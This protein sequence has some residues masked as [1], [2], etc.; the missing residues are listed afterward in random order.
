MKYLST[1]VAVATMMLSTQAQNSTLISNGTVTGVSTVLYSSNC[2]SSTAS[3]VTITR[4]AVVTAT[5]CGEGN[6]T[7]VPTDMPGGTVTVTKLCP[8]CAEETGTLLSGTLYINGS[9]V[10]TATAAST[11]DT[12]E[13]TATMC[14]SCA[15][16]TETVPYSNGTAT[17]ATASMA[18]GTGAVG[19]GN[20]SYTGAMTPISYTGSATREGMSVL[21]LGAAALFVSFL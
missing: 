4:A 17:A 8:V 3:M 7:A 20:A 21:A 10:P 11:V 2:P 15:V 16:E 12:G 9:A 6:F 1:A 14:E 13:S 18:S 19:T 5:A